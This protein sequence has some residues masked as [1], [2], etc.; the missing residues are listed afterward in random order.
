[1]DPALMS[2]VT[3]EAA[4][5]PIAKEAESLLRAALESLKSG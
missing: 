2:Q 4:I 3:G 5:A 1:M